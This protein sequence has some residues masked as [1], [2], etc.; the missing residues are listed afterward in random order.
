MWIV[1]ARTPIGE[2]PEWVRRAWIGLE[3]PVA[4]PH[5]RT[6]RV[7]GVNSGPKTL[8]GGLWALL[9]GR[10]NKISGYS[11]NARAAVDIL[12]TKDAAAAEW[13]RTNAAH[14]LDGRYPFIFDI[15]SCD[16]VRPEATVADG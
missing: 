9:S 11:V 15:E 2:A 12:A 6:W 5:K 10:T 13:W 16:V 8:I 14:L 7:V 3:L 4:H 1:I